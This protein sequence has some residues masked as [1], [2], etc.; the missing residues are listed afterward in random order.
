MDQFGL[1]SQLHHQ[2]WSAQAAGAALLGVLEARADRGSRGHL[3]RRYNTFGQRPEPVRTPT[4]NLC[5]RLSSVGLNKLEIFSVRFDSTQGIGTLTA[6]EGP[7]SVNVRCEQL[8]FPQFLVGMFATSFVVAIWTG[9]ATGSGWMAL[10]WAALTL[11]VLQV[12]YIVVIVYLIYN[13]AS[14]AASASANPS[15]PLHEDGVSL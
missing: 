6:I 9:I 12:G 15:P 11:V 5:T 14:Q 2:R 8:Y 7:V 4:L 3:S 1:A 13:R 10:G